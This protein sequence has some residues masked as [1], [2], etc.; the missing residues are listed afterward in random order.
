MNNDA[1]I[2][3]FKLLRLAAILSF[4]AGCASHPVAIEKKPAPPVAD[5]SF[6]D[7]VG[8]QRALGL[9]SPV[10]SLG[11]AE[12]G[13]DTCAIGFGYSSNHDCVKKKAFVLNFRLQCRESEGT[14][15]TGLTAA[16]LQPIA[17]KTLRW[18]LGSSEGITQTDGEGYAQ[19]SGIANSSPKAQRLRIAVG[20]QFLYIRPGELTRLVVPRPWCE[21]EAK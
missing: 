9:D 7:V 5:G 11:Y 6:I 1:I 21:Q 18:I 13:F 12:K 3:T 16:D 2:R 19:V 17:G 4:L 15:S 14:I 10:E 8:I 20:T